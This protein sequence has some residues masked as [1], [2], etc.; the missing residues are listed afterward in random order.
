MASTNP[1][2]RQPPR[3]PIGRGEIAT[4]A[5]AVVLGLLWG[6]V[7]K[8]SA[9]LGAAASLAP[10]LLL[11]I[12]P[13]L[14]IVLVA[15]RIATGQFEMRMTGWA[16]IA[17]AAAGLVGNLAVPGLAPSAVVPG[18]L[19]GTLDGAQLPTGVPAACTWG[20]GDTSVTQI[21]FPL[22]TPLTGNVPAGQLTIQLPSGAAAIDPTAIGLAGPG[23]P[24]RNGTGGV[25]SGDMSSG[26]LTLDPAQGAVVAGQLAWTCQPAPA[27][28]ATAQP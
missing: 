25:G 8:R 23:M 4:L 9:G 22:R 27:A 21:A 16:A 10:A 1:R 6:I 13:G 2:R 11:V 19:T 18:T 12:G 5:V 20:P 7:W 3:R 26:T 28:D 24:L 15:M 14:V 17:A